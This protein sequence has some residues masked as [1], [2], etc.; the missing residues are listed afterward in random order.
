MASNTTVVSIPPSFNTLQHFFGWAK[1]VPGDK[2]KDLL[3]G[4]HNLHTARKIVLC[5]LRIYHPDKCRDINARRYSQTLTDLKNT[6]DE[7]IADDAESEST[8]QAAE[9]KSTHQAAE[10]ESSHQ[11]AEAKSWRHIVEENKQKPVSFCKFSDRPGGCTN[12][13][14]FYA[15]SDSEIRIP[16][17]ILGNDDATS[18]Y[19]NEQ[20]KARRDATSK[21]I[22]EQLKARRDASKRIQTAKQAVYNKRHK[23]MGTDM[24]FEISPNGIMVFGADGCILET[25]TFIVANA[26]KSECSFG[27][28]CNKK[29]CGY[30]H[31]SEDA[32]QFLLKLQGHQIRLSWMQHRVPSTSISFFWWD[33]VFRY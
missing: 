7:L 9:T 11:A 33:Q 4:E 32:G 31:P 18:K 22:S 8:R 2:V 30:R 12:P 21:Y 24:T 17:D 6:L 20:L 15:H 14:C 25:Y 16:E 1:T 28:S 10:A 13:R 3:K 19:I 5:L 23:I 29:V 26:K 27:S